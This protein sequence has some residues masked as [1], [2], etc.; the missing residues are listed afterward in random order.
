MPLK[1]NDIGIG[2][3]SILEAFE[4][5]GP[6][7][8]RAEN[9]HP[10]FRIEKVSNNHYAV[11]VDVAGYEHDDISI[12]LSD[13]VLKI[14]MNHEKDDNFYT[15]IDTDVYMLFLVSRNF[16]LSETSV[17]NGILYMTFINTYTD[18]RLM[19]IDFA[20]SEVIANDAAPKDVEVTKVTV[21]TVV[22]EFAI[23]VPEVKVV[24]APEAI[25]V[26]ELPVVEV[27]PEPVVEVPV[28]IE[29][30]PEPVVEPVVVAE[31]VPEPTPEVVVVE[32]VPE[33]P[34]PVIE[35]VPD[36]KVEVVVVNADDKTSP[37]TAV[38]VPLEM[39]PVVEVVVTAEPL[40]DVA[41][42]VPQVHIEL[43][44]LVSDAPILHDKVVVPIATSNPEKTDVSIILD[45]VSA[46]VLA[47][48]N[49]DIVDVVTKAIEESKTELPPVVII[50]PTPEPTPEVVPEPVVE[51]VAEVVPEPV[52]EPTPEVVVAE[53]V[54]EPV[55][56][57]VPEP[58]PEVVAEVVAETPVVDPTH[59][60][61]EDVLVTATMPES[62][63]IVS[64]TVLVEPAP[65]EPVA[66]T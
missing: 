39:T 55:I 22:A 2:F 10:P 45:P 16:H 36:E 60:V 54:P 13:M 64:F 44:P 21:E 37:T 50:E 32:V 6:I 7:L 49:V 9:E 65:A 52:V 20:T 42:E 24:P 28:V 46:E 58:T 3:D 15:G 29:Q 33:V 18:K 38:S 62:N 61:S 53:A 43:V 12:D 56:E 14:S 48:A 23:A 4:S 59:V 41:S 63:V 31:I 57:V 11:E 8:N 47:N 40:I 30:V 5:L 1:L 17:K 34:V 25:S 26:M 51:T 66:N 27:Q 35:I 19:S